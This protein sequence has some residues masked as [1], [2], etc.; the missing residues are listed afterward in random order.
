MCNNLQW[1]RMAS[2]DLYVELCCINT[3]GCYFANTV[4]INNCINTHTAVCT[5]IHAEGQKDGRLGA[6]PGERMSSVSALHQP[7]LRC[8]TVWADN[9]LH[10]PAAKCAFA[11][12]PR[13]THGYPQRTIITQKHI[14]VYTGNLKA[15]VC[16]K[17]DCIS[18]K[19]YHDETRNCARSIYTTQLSKFVT[20]PGINLRERRNTLVMRKSNYIT[21]NI[22]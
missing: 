11:R 4:I 22:C 14:H 16:R 6:G 19:H 5:N 2:D 17:G 12:R 1:S 20:S 18:S 13:P 3:C 9:S 7:A 21:I 15:K 10:Q 8:S